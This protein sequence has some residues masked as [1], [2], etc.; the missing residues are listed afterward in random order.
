MCCHGG[1]VSHLFASNQKA[2]CS[3]R[4]ALRLPLR[5]SGWWFGTEVQILGA[6]PV[7]YQKKWPLFSHLTALIVFLGMM[8]WGTFVI[9]W[10][11]FL[12]RVGT[13]APIF[14]P[15]YGFGKRI[16]VGFQ[17][18]SSPREWMNE[19]ILK[20]WRAARWLFLW[21][22]V[23]MWGMNLAATYRDADLL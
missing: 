17:V 6:E 1:G 20:V 23:S 13:V 12:F 2:V 21:I 7:S 22:A 3:N 10:L 4:D 14:F 16:G 5:N 18:T 19:V 11:A 8:R 15:R 9:G